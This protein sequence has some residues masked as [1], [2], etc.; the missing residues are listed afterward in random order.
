M[1]ISVRKDSMKRTIGALAMSIAIVMTWQST[2]SAQQQTQ[3]PASNLAVNDT[4]RLQTDLPAAN[5]TVNL[6][7]AVA[8]WTLDQLASSGTGMDTVHVWAIPPVGAATFV[9]VA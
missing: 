1:I 6:P 5:A 7:F 8:G 3:T 2:T 9:G 4:V